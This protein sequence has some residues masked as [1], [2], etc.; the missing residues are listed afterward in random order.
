[1]SNSP[2]ERHTCGLAD[3]VAGMADVTLLSAMPNEIFTCSHIEDPDRLPCDDC[4]H[5]PCGAPPT[6]GCRSRASH[7]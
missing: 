1:M 7:L 3:L 5:S 4:S 6:A 2:A